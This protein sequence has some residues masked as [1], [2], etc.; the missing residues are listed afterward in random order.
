M[1]YPSLTERLINQHTTAN[2]I[3]ASV[4]DEKIDHQPVPGKWSIH[5][6]IVHLA[7]YQ[8]VYLDRIK[9]IL[10]ENK[11]MFGR[12]VA[13]VDNNFIALRHAPVI[14]L[15]AK[16]AEER[17]EITELIFSLNEAEYLR[18]GSHLKYGNLTVV[19]WTEFFLLHE[20]HHLFAMFQ[21]AHA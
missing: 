5:D 19:E 13:D 18:T 20:A 7:T 14:E 6:H 4:S 15:L 2:V 21:L 11:P 10:A 12:Y 8:P 3:V 9:L 16:I 17:K 1:L